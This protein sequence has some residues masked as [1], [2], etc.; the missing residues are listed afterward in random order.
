MRITN[1]AD[2]LESP[3][4]QEFLTQ[5]EYKNQVICLV[6]D[7]F[8]E[9]YSKPEVFSVFEAAQSLFLST[10]AAQ[11]NLVLGFAWKTDSTV[12]QDHPA[13]YMWHRLA[14]HRM[15]VGLGQF[16]SSEASNAI[17]IFQKELGEKLRSDLRR[18]LIEN[19]Q[20]YPWFLK[21]LCIHVHDTVKS[22]TSQS[23]LVDQDLNVKSLFDKD[24]QQ[25]TSSE[26]ICLKMISE[27]APVDW[28]E[29]LNDFGSEILSG[30]QDKRLIV[31]SGNRLNLYWDIFREYVQ[32]NMVPSIPFSY[33]PSSPS[34]RAL[35]K[36]VE[37][38]SLE[39]GQNYAEL[40]ELCGF[41]QKTIGNVIHDLSMFRIVTVEQ[42]EARLASPMEVSDQEKILQRLRRVLQSH[43]LTMRLSNRD[44]GDIITTLDIIQLLKQIN[45]AAQHQEKTWRTY[46][47]KMG[48]W[49]SVT[50]YLIQREN[51]WKLEDQGKVNIESIE[52]NRKARKGGGITVFIGDTSPIK[53][54][55][56]LDYLRSNQPLSTK[57]IQEKGFRNAVAA[58]RGLVVLQC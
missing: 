16:T 45:P 22:G 34:I 52:K 56:A 53:T 30:L 8:E 4:I 5:L 29:V 3:S 7:Q 1:S 11:S 27:S 24:L 40:S 41:S 48:H 18:Q 15:E 54:L 19:S 49:L 26:D 44:Q 9:L 43:A 50:G 10:V 20:G 47:E 2:P 58:L 31:R 38:L 33:L 57:E 46:A 13:Y 39:K 21:K 55:E 23:E 32:T 35:L 28:S 37:Q 17:S 25:L 51:D 42:S 6:F 14:D 36:V 12:Q